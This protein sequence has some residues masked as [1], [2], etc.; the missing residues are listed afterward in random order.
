MSLALRRKLAEQITYIDTDSEPRILHYGEDFLLEDL[1][2][3]TRVIYPKPPIVGLPNPEAAIRY[4]LNRPLGC[5]P[6]HAQLYPGMKVTIAVD[7]ISLPLP[8]MKT[9]EIRQQVLEIVLDML[10][11]HG[12]DDIHII[13]ANSLHRKMT[14]SDRKST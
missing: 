10:T 5:D 4:A 3:G 9:P 8:P 6:L 11:G 14:E 7:D 2:V 1:P 12:V 13:V